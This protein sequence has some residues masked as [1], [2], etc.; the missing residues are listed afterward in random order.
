M[1][2]INRSAKPKKRFT[3]LNCVLAL[4]FGLIIFGVFGY[5][6]FRVWYGNGVSEKNSD[7]TEIVTFEIES[8]TS[9]SEIGQK[10][11]DNGLIKSK[12][13]WDLYVRLNGGAKFL[14]DKYSLPKNLSLKDVV[15]TLQRPAEKRVIWVTIAEGRSLKQ[16]SKLLQDRQ[17]EFSGGQFFPA[18]FVSITDNPYIYEFDSEIDEFLNKYKP[19]GKSLEGFLYPETYAFEVDMTAMEMVEMILKEFIKQVSKLDL[20]NGKMSFYEALTL[21]SIVEREGINDDDRKTI[22]GIFANRLDI[23]MPLQSDATVNYATGKSDLRATYEDIQS[24]SPYNT[25]KVTGL[26]PTPITNPRL[27]AIEVSLNPI[28]TDYYYFIHAPDRTPYYARNENEHYNNV[29]KYLDGK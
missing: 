7:S 25:Y 28:D 27:Q 4:I 16:I 9:T 1:N 18:D 14:A 5:M 22:A 20:D 12:T 21:S 23:K 15:D 2:E 19:A 11:Y 3:P 24:H 8:G 29:A 13:L 10:L 6:T 26:P 17:S